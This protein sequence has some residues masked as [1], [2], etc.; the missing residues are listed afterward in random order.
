MTTVVGI[1][2]KGVSHL[3]ADTLLTS[4]ETRL[5]NA[6]KLIETDSISATSQET[7][8]T[9][10]GVAGPATCLLAL[11]LILKES[12]YE[13]ATTI[14]VYENM[15]ALHGELRENHGLRV[16]EDGNPFED[17]HFQALV[18]NKYGLWKVLS[19][20]EV[21]PVEHL[22]SIGTGREFALG[23]LE[24]L[25]SQDP[26][27]AMRRALSIASHYDLQTSGEPNLW[28]SKRDPG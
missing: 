23:A 13:W 9:C 5:G 26:E 27:A 6:E 11:R 28:S 3:A 24:A 20:R 8:T 17:S 4:G 12:K 19:F 25:G 16:N 10:I 2:K 22:G 1:R 15:L 14:D 18:A 21:I 7:Y